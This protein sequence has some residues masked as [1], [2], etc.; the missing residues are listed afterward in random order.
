MIKRALL[1]I[2]ALLLALVLAVAVGTIGRGSRQLAVQPLAPLAVDKDGAAASLGAAI[3]AKTISGLPDPS[4]VARE[5][6]A[7]QAHLRE[8]YPL[9]HARL[10]RE[11]V[12]EHTLLYTWKGG[13]PAAK[14]IALMPHQD[15]VPIAPGTEQ[16]WKHPPFEGKVIGGEVWGRGAWD[17]KANLVSQFEA[18]EM[19]LKA[20]FSP[21][22]TVYLILGHDEEVGGRLGAAKVAALLK[23]RKVKLDWLLTEGLL[24]TE[25]ILPGVDAPIALIG[26]AE[27]GY[28]SVRLVAEAPPGHSSL[29]PGAGKSAIG[30]L[31]AALAR[32]DQQPLPA[33]VQGIASE[34]FG[35]L[36]PEM[37]GFQRVALSNLWLF[38]PVVERMLAGQ[39]STNAM[40]RT[41]TA[42][43]IVNAGNK[44]NVL[45]GRAEALVNFRILP[46]DTVES[47]VAHVKRAVADDRI[48]VEKLGE[49]GEASPVSS[50]SA[51]GYRHIERGIR[52]VF[53]GALVAPG[54]MLAGTDAKHFV[55]L[56]DQLY[57]FSPLRAGPAELSRPHGTDE[58]MS[59]D[60]VA[61]M[62]RFYHRLLQLAAGSPAP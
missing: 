11:V 19:L 41:T 27:K 15:V 59:V 23:Q 43:T 61:D 8:R 34:M 44:E 39:P 3:R 16:L 50:T 52:E 22:R 14:P 38:K 55:G 18:V 49:G 40:M 31:S 25:K 45:P 48:K 9:V 54:L 29:P 57:R 56:A 37:G 21:R 24:V 4:G 42:M 28:L 13:D 6:E 58:R 20:G 10:E 60:I 30:M 32:L 46:G 26:V 2:A 51:E 1:V 35:T 5:F 47:V 62:V 17:D 7:L 12:A 36:A 33:G 53:P